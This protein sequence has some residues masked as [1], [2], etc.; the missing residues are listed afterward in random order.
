MFIVS[1]RSDNESSFKSVLIPLLKELPV[2][3]STNL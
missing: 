2:M 1:V 3:R